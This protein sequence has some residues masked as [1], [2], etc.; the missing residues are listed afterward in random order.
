[1]NYRHAY[2][3]GN[4]ADVSKHIILTLIIEHQKK[5]EA[6]FRIID[7]HAGIGLYDL[8][9][10]ESAKTNEWTLGIGRLFDKNVSFQNEVLLEPYMQVVKEQ[11][12][13]GKLQFYPGSPLLSRRLLRPQDRLIANELHPE[14]YTN[15]AKLFLK[16]QQVKVLNLDGWIALKSL[17]PPKEKRGIV[18]IDPPFE[19]SGEFDRIV[20][21]I[22]EAYRR[23]ATGTFILWYPIKDLKAIEEFY[24]KISTLKVK[25]I[26]I[27]EIYMKPVQKDEQLKGC[28][29][30][31]I[32]PP[33]TLASQLH[34]FLPELCYLLR[35]DGD[36]APFFVLDTHIPQRRSS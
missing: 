27:A 7:T 15:L 32:N 30:L 3:A 18:L 31:I 28:G 29:H 4:F 6:G 5:K 2:H 25:N 11:N 13:K 36:C 12:P 8:R 24:A 10:E 16:D 14:D 20:D 23:F 22:K 21:G 17:L 34:R 33:F 19:K 26:L 1:M 35:G 9:G